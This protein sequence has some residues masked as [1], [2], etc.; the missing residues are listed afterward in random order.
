[1]SSLR[2]WMIACLAA[3]A[4]CASDPPVAISA[5]TWHQ[6]DN[7]IAA[8]SHAASAQAREQA[9]TAMKRWMTLVYRET[10][11]EFI[12]WFSSYWTQQWLSMKVS[13]YKLSAD[14]DQDPTVN[15]LALYLQEQY[16]EIVLEP[17]AETIE[18][19][20]IMENSTRFYVRY[21]QHHVPGIGQRHGIAEEQFEQRLKDIP[22][23]ALAPGASLY[24]LLH[25]DPPEQL[26]AYRALLERIRTAPGGAGDWSTNPGISSVA[27]RTSKRLVGELTTSGAASAVSAMVGR[28][29]GMTISLGVALFTAIA[30]ADE[31]PETEA[32]L[33]KNLNAAFDQE[34][35]ELLRSPE[36]GVLAGVHQLSGQIEGGLVWLAPVRFEPTS[37][38]QPIWSGGSD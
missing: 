14:G 33:R 10:D 20:Q 24:Q 23:I 3:L 18:P 13:W 6:V 4:G 34:W 17:V 31:R 36:R 12:P 19:K 11:E 37:P 30:R 16:Q 25:A 32:Q 29:A 7:D 8:A 38:G 35:Q 22:A 28:A 9:L 2:A 26:P 1:M 15:R 21:L 5:S 27:Q